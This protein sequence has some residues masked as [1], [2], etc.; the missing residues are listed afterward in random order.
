M[1]HLRQRHRWGIVIFCRAFLLTKPPSSN[2]PHNY[3]SLSLHHPSPSTPFFLF[4]FA[5]STVSLSSC[6]VPFFISPAPLMLLSSTFFPLHPW[7]HPPSIITLGSSLSPALSVSLSLSF[8]VLFQ[9]LTHCYFSLSLF[10]FFFLCRGL[11][12]AS[13]PCCWVHTH[14]IKHEDR[15]TSPGCVGLR[16]AL[17]W[18]RSAHQGV[19]A[20]VHVSSLCPLSW[21]GEVLVIGQP[22]V[23]TG[24]PVWVWSLTLVHI[25][26]QNCL[27]N[28]SEQ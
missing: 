11:K 2:R 16:S 27:N 26:M 3:T 24:L 6:F 10:S 28:N 17:L 22:T 23:E 19:G 18:Y 5:Y 15:H 20:S 9:P 12:A 25:I 21:E 13:L 1:L 7:F 4:P 14:M 8:S